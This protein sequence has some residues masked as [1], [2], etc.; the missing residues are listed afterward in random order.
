MLNR[1]KEK[2]IATS[3]YDKNHHQES[4]EDNHKYKRGFSDHMW[5]LKNKVDVLRFQPTIGLHL[6]FVKQLLDRIMF[7]LEDYCISFF[8]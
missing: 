8:P 2:C 4:K 3:E 6:N 7:I 5:W 1:S